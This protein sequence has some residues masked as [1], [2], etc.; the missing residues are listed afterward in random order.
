MTGYSLDRAG[1][2]Q[3]F[4]SSEENFR[5]V[6]SLEDRNLVVPVSGDF[7]GQKAIR[8]IGA[9]LTQQGGVVSAFYLS[10]VEQYLF[11]DQHAQAFYDNVATLPTDAKSVFIRPYSMRRFGRG[12]YPGG[13]ADPTAA[14]KSLCPIEPFLQQAKAGK[15]VSNELALSCGP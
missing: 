11:Q 1:L 12:G 13:S 15:I 9:W 5:Y 8:A 4:L 10:N 14:V 7:G 6:K 3:S 2:P